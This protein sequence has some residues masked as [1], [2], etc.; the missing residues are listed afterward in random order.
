VGKEL[1]IITNVSKRFHMDNYL[2]ISISTVQ[3]NMAE[4]TLQ[5][6]FG[7]NATQDSSYLTIYK[8]DLTGLVPSSD[9]TAESL[10][11]ALVLQAMTELNPTKQETNVDI[12]VTLEKSFGGDS[13]V[14]RNNQSYRQYSY[15]LKLQKLDTST[16]VNPSDF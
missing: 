14:T 13:I 7:A 8:S 2:S 15:D 4:P 3:K 12:Q 11:V 9:N 10:L 1:R 16:T 5:Q 6:V